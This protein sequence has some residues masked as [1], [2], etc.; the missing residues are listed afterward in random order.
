M[1]VKVLV[2]AAL[3]VTVVGGCGGCD[4]NKEAFD[5]I[6]GS[7]QDVSKAATDLMNQIN[8]VTRLV[9][10]KVESGE[11]GQDVGDVVDQRLS[12][13]MAQLESAMQNSGGYLFDQANGTIDHTFIDISLLLDQINS[14]ILNKTLPSLIDQISS[15]LQL[16]INTISTT[17]EDLVVLTAGSAV[18]IVDKTVNAIVIIV[19]I[20]FL[21]IGV[22]VFAVI[23]IKMKGNFSVPN[24]V[25]VSFMGIFT[26]FFLT[27][28][29][30]SDLRGNVIAGFNFGKKVPIREL[31]P[32]ITGVVPE[33]FVLGKTKNLYIY[34]THLNAL[35]KIK[36]K[37]MQNTTEKVVFPDSTIIVATNNRIVLGNFERK[38]GWKLPPFAAFK[39]KVQQNPAFVSA[40]DQSINAMSYSM[41]AALAQHLTST[42]QAFSDRAL[43]AA[44]NRA[45]LSAVR[46]ALLL[47]EL[48]QARLIGIG[49]A[50]GSAQTRAFNTVINNFYLDQFKIPEGQ[51]GLVVF[52]D[53]TKIESPQLFSVLN[54]PPPAMDPDISPVNI[55]WAGG[56]DPVAGQSTTLEVEFSVQY[57]ENITTPFMAK[58]TSIPPITPIEVTVPMGIIAAAKGNNRALALTRAFTAP[59]KG[60]YVFTVSAD[61]QNVVKESN[62]GNN[63]LTRNLNV[64][65]YTYDATLTSFGG[66][67]I[68][69][70][71]SAKKFFMSVTADATGLPTWGCSQQVAI[72]GGGKH[73]INC[74]TTLPGLKPGQIILLTFNGIATLPFP[75]PFITGEMPI[76]LGSITWNKQIVLNPTD[77]QDSKEFIIESQTESCK[78]TGKLILTRKKSY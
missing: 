60:V 23:L 65:E 55:R 44:N 13:L 14:G 67:I 75:I 28:I 29:L 62:E 72:V 32:K 59:A 4:I 68:G 34:G 3:L 12:N 76:G 30:S 64:G 54:P 61:E 21:A 51:Y 48:Q 78:Y 70:L 27:I 77:F 26:I 1:K 22:F 24:I 56:I 57:P 43:I 9:D 45:P 2:I 8:D 11:L 39:M 42:R 18:I 38:L 6:A 5:K 66:E 47:G 40:S 16:Q 58:I 73:S 17:V 7:I 31:P 10:S 71:S 35:Q 25:G 49:R 69:G 20:I 37:L 50:L 33:T 36:V 19:S 41:N 63:T 15:Q 74:A 46:P 53:T 52:A